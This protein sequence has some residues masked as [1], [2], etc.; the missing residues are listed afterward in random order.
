MRPPSSRY[1]SSRA[2]RP[3]PLKRLSPERLRR[4]TSPARAIA[5]AHIE[6]WSGQPTVRSLA[7]PAPTSHPGGSRLSIRSRPTCRP[8]ASVAIVSVA[9][10]FRIGSAGYP[11]Q[12]FAFWHR[13]D[14]EALGLRD[15]SDLLTGPQ[16]K[17][18]TDFLWN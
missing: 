11:R 12:V 5:T 2:Q 15:E 17:L 7:A 18:L 6:Q 1:L 14:Q 16:T 3:T 4:P 8:R 9:I 13:D 10:A